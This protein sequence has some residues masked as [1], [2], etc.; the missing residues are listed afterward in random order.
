M[1][2]L[3]AGLRRAQALAGIVGFSGAILDGAKLPREITARPPVLLVHGDADPVVPVESLGAVKSA[4]GA[5][6]VAFDAHVIPGLQHGIDDQGAML[7]A[8]F[9]QS[10]LNRP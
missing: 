10:K 1:M 5:A 8:A 3:H 9:L 4:L 6:N 2:A 7:A